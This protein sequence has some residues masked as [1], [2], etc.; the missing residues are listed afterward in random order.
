MRRRGRTAPPRVGSLFS[1]C[2]GL[3][4]GFEA[5][6]YQLLAARDIDP[7]VVGVFNTN[8]P[9]VASVCDL[10]AHD[11]QLPVIDVLLA[12]SPCQGF[13]TAGKC[14]ASDPRNSFLMK[15][16]QI[17]LD[18]GA[19][20]F[21]LENVP[22]AATGRNSTHWRT[23]ENML[24][25]NGYN[26]GRILAEGLESGLAQNRR[27]LF[28]VAWRGSDCIRFEVPAMGHTLLWNV[29]SGV[30]NAVDH[31]PIMLP[32][33]SAAAR[34][35]RRISP[36]Q[37]LSNVRASSSAV[38]TWQ[39]PEVYGPVTKFET[40]VLEGVLRLRRRERRRAFGDGDPVSCYRLNTFLGCSASKALKSLIAKGY[41]RRVGRDVELV[42]T[43]NGKFRRL[44]WNEP[45]PTVDT[46][47]GDPALFLH[48]EE[49]RGF[50][51]REAARIQGFDDSFQFTGSRRAQFSMIGNAVPPPMAAR[52]A[53]FVRAALL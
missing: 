11:P 50:S 35:A 20:V 46:H 30:S 49:D 39:I 19:Q 12:G 31:K 42:H 27:R 47:F 9:P 33:H 34:I 48:P 28:L 29:L 32:A 7:M 21:V 36:G 37:K 41:L 14:V 40:R 23:L 10:S 8:L 24:R 15:A 25:W 1:G 4:K 18:S 2:G 43:Y 3:D 51:T 38:H 13:S 26:V 45:S 22:A 5:R 17:A 53:E 52:M 44:A 6:G 16:G